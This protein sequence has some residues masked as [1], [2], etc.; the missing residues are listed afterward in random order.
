[1]ADQSEATDPALLQ[2]A[3]GAYGLEVR[4]SENATRISGLRQQGCCRIL[5]PR[6][7][8]GT[9]EAVLVNVSG[10]IAAGDRISGDIVCRTGSCLTVTTQAAE[11]IYKAREQ[12]APARIEARCTVESGAR[13]DW[14]PLETIFFDRSA[15][16]RLLEIDMAG[17]A[18]VL[19][20][21]TRV[22]GRSGSDE[23]VEHIRLRDRLRIKRD[24]ELL[25]VESL[26]AEG[27]LARLLEQKAIAA[28]RTV[29]LTLWLVAPDAEAWLALVREALGTQENGVEAAASAWNGMLVVRALGVSNLA[30]SRLSRRLLSILREGRGDPVTWRA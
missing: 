29:M 19:G 30:I 10:G 2:R 21:E 17:D 15:T 12:D 5:M 16:S 28:G 8:Q 13:L 9:P 18:I 11:R 4:L 26:I 1:M 7:P 20:C 22:F 23:T 3:V 14:L 6:R 25:W 27:P 24:D